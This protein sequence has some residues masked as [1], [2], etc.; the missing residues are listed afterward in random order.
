MASAQLLELSAGRETTKQPVEL[1]LSQ[2]SMHGTFV[3][4]R[5]IKENVFE[6]N[7]PRRA[8]ER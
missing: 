2:T 3:E 4:L 6:Q 7:A 5:R 1:G 8:T